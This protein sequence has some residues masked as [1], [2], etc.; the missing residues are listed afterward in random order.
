MQT[1]L[2]NIEEK[3]EEFITVHQKSRDEWNTKVVENRNRREQVNGQKKEL[4]DEIERQ[5]TV[6]DLENSKVREAKVKREG[7][8]KAFGALRSE[9][10]GDEGPRQRPKGDSP[11]FIKKK[12]RTLEMRFE[13]GQISGQK[14]EK[15]F[16]REM[17]EL[18]RKLRESQTRRGPQTGGNS[19]AQLDALKIACDEAHSQVIAA[20]EAA[21]S[22]HDLM[23]RL[24]DETRRLNDQH[25]MSHR[26]FVTAKTEADRE[27]QHYIV[28]MRC[29]WSARH[30]LKAIQNRADGIQPAKAEASASNVDLM[31]ALMSGQTLST[32][33]LMAMQRDD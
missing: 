31:S 30:L 9:L 24:K 7:A 18:S 28:A 23:G 32:E 27:H 15:K 2:K 19:N 20:A 17:K 12:M 1:T 6:R 33:Q 3:T 16:N 14:E 26:A 5:R 4:Y 29:T 8:N 11:E 13:T 22:A 25:E 10:F 21:Q